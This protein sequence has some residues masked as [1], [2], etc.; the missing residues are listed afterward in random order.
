MMQLPVEFSEYMRHLLGENEFE[1][2]SEAL[3]TDPSVSIRVNPWKWQDDFFLLPMLLCHG[4]KVLIICLP[5]CLL[6][7]IH[8]F[9]PVAIMYRKLLLC[10][11]IVS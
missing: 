5:V 4:R 8:C 1:A 6:L 9:M 10:L 3:Q 7:L 2:L 11:C